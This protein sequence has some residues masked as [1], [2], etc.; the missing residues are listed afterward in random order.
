MSEQTLAEL[1]SEAEIKVP[2][3]VCD[4]CED[5]GAVTTDQTDQDGF[6]IEIACPVCGGKII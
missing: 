4:A 6:H 3:F 2:P 5:S 1:Q